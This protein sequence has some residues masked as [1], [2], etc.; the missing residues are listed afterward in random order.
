MTTRCTNCGSI[1]TTFCE[2]HKE[3]LDEIERLRFYE[4]TSA[5][6]AIRMLKATEARLAAVTAARDEL[7]ILASTLLPTTL[8]DQGDQVRR[9]I[10]ALHK[11]G[12]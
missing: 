5:A 7:A 2:N 1:G 10:A 3:L 9:R 12:S 8:A 4:T 6:E 11:A